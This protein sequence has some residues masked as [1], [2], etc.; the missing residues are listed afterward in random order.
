MDYETLLV[1]VEDRVVVI[2][3][4]RPRSLNALNRKLIEELDQ[5]LSAI[6]GDAEVGVVIIT[7]QEKFFAVG[8]DIPEISGLDT[9][10]A[11]QGFRHPSQPGSQPPGGPA[12][13]GHCRG[14]R[15]GPGRRLRTGPVLRPPDRG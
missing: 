8:A 15:S 3:L 9:P 5:A 11:A 14:V 1:Q 4:N 10:L 7:G 13:T 12:Q 6:E 2:A